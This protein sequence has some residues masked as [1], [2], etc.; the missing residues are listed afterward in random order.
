MC[1]CQVLCD[2]VLKGNI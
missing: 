2:A 1:M